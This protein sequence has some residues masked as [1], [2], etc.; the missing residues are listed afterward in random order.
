MGSRSSTRVIPLIPLPT[1][2]LLLPGTTLRV[3]IQGRAD[4]AALLANIYSRAST[5]KADSI[6]IGCVPLNSANIS[7]DGRRLI[8]EKGNVG[9]G[10]AFETDPVR[11]TKEDLFSFLCVGRVSGVQGRRQ[12]ELSLVVEGVSRARIISIE[13]ERPYFEAKVAELEDGGMEFRYASH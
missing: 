8:E 5:D 12:G 1:S 7:K 11:A 3:P 4:L 10:R 2:L 9:Q 13:K 6:V